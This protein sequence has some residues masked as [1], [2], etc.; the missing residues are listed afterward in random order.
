MLLAGDEKSWALP[1]VALQKAM[2][3]EKLCKNIC[4]INIPR[5]II[6]KKSLK[7]YNE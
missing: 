4:S 5:D 1:F 6:M 7:I 3:H 2:E